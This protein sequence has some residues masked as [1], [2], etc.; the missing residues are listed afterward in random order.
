MNNIN[1]HLE[2]TEIDRK[3]EQLRID[4][5]K[6]SVGK[7]RFITAGATLLKDR[8]AKLIRLEESA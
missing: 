7:K 4:Y 2:I 3:L 6:A 5:V 8:R 1:I